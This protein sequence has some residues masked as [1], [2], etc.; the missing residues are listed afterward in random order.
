MVNAAGST[1]SSSSHVDRRRHRRGG[2][3]AGAVRARHRAVAVGLVEV[4][5]DP[6][7]ALL[8]PPVRRDLV[9]H[10]PLEL[11][12]RG[13][14][15]VTHLEELVGRL[16]RAEDVDAA[17]A[18][19]LDQRLEPRLGRTSRSACAAGT[20][21]AK[22]VPGC[23]SRSMR[24]STGLS[25]SPASDAHGWNTIVFICTAHTI[26]AGLGQDELGMPPT[27]VVRDGDRLDVPGCALRRVLGEER[28][29]VDR[30][31]VPLERDRPVAV[32][33]QE[34]AR[35]REHVLR[36]LVLGDAEVG[37]QHAVRARQPDL[38]IPVG[39]GHGQSDALARHG[40]TLLAPSGT[41]EDAP[42]A[43]RGPMGDAVRAMSGS[44]GQRAPGSACASR[45]APG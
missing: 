28:L 41:R 15:R 6:L 17:V 34:R 35:H 38:A 4:D 7:A 8:L 2:Q 25:V 31:G 39:S 44:R 16:D 37:P 45:V 30:L 3:R 32:R 29:S 21:S 42:P 14:H 43:G 5:E 10:A 20:A 23:G 9:G 1:P 19:R 12:R 27:A 24:S 13:D 33:G 40:S 18:A 26:A 22:S 36:E 11:A